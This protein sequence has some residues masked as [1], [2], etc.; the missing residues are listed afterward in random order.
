[1]YAIRFIYTILDTE[2]MVNIQDA[3]PELYTVVS[4]TH[5]SA[6]KRH[7]I[8]WFIYYLLFYPIRAQLGSEFRARIQMLHWSI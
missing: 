3:A 5:S 6:V 7:I 4:V 2:C 1:M 8:H